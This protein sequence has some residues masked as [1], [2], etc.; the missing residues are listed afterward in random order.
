MSI[1]ATGRDRASRSIDVENKGLKRLAGCWALGALALML[2]ARTAPAARGEDPPDTC[3]GQVSDFVDFSKPPNEIEG[4]N[5]IRIGIQPGIDE[6]TKRP[7]LEVSGIAYY[8]DNVV[9]TVGIRHAKVRTC[10]DQK[11]VVVKDHTFTYKF[12]PFL[13][14]MPGGGLVIEADFVLG[15]QPPAVQKELAAGNFFKNSPPCKHDKGNRTEVTY[16]QGGGE[17]E[18]DAV[19]AEKDVIGAFR[20]GTLDAYTVCGASLAGGAGN[21]SA[22]LSKLDKDLDDVAAVF[23]TWRAGR[24]FTL[25][26]NRIAQLKTLKG[27]IRDACKYRAAAAGAPIP[28]VPAANAASMQAAEDKEV[29]KLADEVKG[30]LDET[31][32]LD[33]AF[34]ASAKPSSATPAPAN[35]GDAKPPENPPRK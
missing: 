4:Q 24:Q 16:S 34:E 35:G 28:N 25:F 20:K 27:H 15:Q 33:K 5:K 30:F 29:T 17:A 14:A 21:A 7:T 23:N 13:K 3:G 9:I 22:A 6:K 26:P 31:N 11:K 8:P 2:L 12:G 10:F 19:K 1:S 32:S 18:Q